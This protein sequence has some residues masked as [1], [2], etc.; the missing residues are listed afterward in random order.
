M[1]CLRRIFQCWSLAL[2]IRIRLYSFYCC[3]ILIWRSSN[4]FWPENRLN[5]LAAVSDFMTLTNP[6]RFIRFIFITRC[7]TNWCQFL[8]GVL[9]WRDSILSRKNWEKIFRYELLYILRDLLKQCQQK[10]MI[11]FH[12]HPLKMS[13]IISSSSYSNLNMIESLCVLRLLNLFFF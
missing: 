8:K 10:R 9:S 1:I 7:N 13:T 3:C 5:K 4:R 6:F 2:F 12:Y 11:G